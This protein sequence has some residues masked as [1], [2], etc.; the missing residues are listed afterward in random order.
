MPQRLLK[1]RRE[2]EKQFSRDAF[3]GCGC[4]L[5]ETVRRHRSLETMERRGEAA[6]VT[7][8]EKMM[9]ALA[10]VQR[11]ECKQRVVLEFIRGQRAPTLRFEMALHAKIL[12]VSI[13]VPLLTPPA[14]RRLLFPFRQY[15]CWGRF[16]RCRA[17]GNPVPARD[18]RRSRSARASA[19]RCSEC[20]KSSAS[21]RI[22]AS[23]LATP[24]PAMSGAEP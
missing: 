12:P 8:G 2:N 1:D 11:A 7:A 18:R 19:S 22:V 15:R 23:G 9:I 4:D 10:A 20:R 5:R 21:A 16:R 17:S 6:P 24:L 14:P 13:R 3:A